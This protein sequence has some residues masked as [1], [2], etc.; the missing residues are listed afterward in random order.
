MTTRPLISLPIR[1]HFALERLWSLSRREWWLGL[2]DRLLVVTAALA[3]ILEWLPVTTLNIS[4]YLWGLACLFL[5]DHLIIYVTVLFSR[6]HLTELW[7]DNYPTVATLLGSQEIL[8]DLF[9]RLNIASES[10]IKL[11]SIPFDLSENNLK[12]PLADLLL[13][14]YEA[15]PEAKSLLERAGVTA[16]QVR[17]A[18]TWI[19][20]G[21]E[22]AYFKQAWWR[23]ENLATIPGLAKDWH[24]GETYNLEQYGHFIEVPEH[25]ATFRSPAEEAMEQVLNREKEANVV[26][27]GELSASLQVLAELGTRINHG[28]TWPRLE[29]KQLLLLETGRLLANFEHQA[30]LPETL[31]GLVT[32]A[33]L[34]GNVILVI[35]DLP[36]LSA[37][38]TRLGTPLSGLLDTYLASAALTVIGLSDP[39]S[40]HGVLEP[41]AVLMN[42]FETV[43]VEGAVGEQVLNLVG[44]RVLELEQQ[45]GLYFTY[46]AV[47]ALAQSVENYFSAGTPAAEAEDLMSELIPA[48]IKKGE[49]RVGKE[50]ILNFVKT[51]TKIPMG[52]VSGLEREKLLSLEKHLS[53]RVVGQERAL[54]ALSSAI[55][56]SR[57]GTRS[58]SRPIGTFL[59]LGPTGVGK[60]ETA[61]ALAQTLFGR[62]EDLLRL[63]MSEY[64]SNDSLARLIGDAGSGTPGILAKL[65]RE[66][67]YGVLLLDEFEKTER[68]VLNLF[69]QIFDE[70]FFSDMAGRRVNMRSLVMIATSNAGA[71]LIWK[72]VDENQNLESESSKITDYLIEQGLFKPELLNRFDSV[73]IF[74]PL[75][76]VALKD[77][78]KRELMKL[79]KRLEDQGVTLVITDLL[80]E[81]LA[82]RG[83]NRQFGARP[84]KRLLQETVEEEVAKALI[85]GTLIS[86]HKVS[87]IPSKNPDGNLLDLDL[88]V[89]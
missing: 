39:S 65:A 17:S 44:T 56:R 77:I 49:R 74:E 45:T 13:Q 72:L 71:Q 32:E 43:T 3:L 52:E 27:V 64:A 48:L 67:P 37:Y 7:S 41:D 68:E 30:G 20:A 38:L 51:K 36:R 8:L 46:Q 31:L 14:A 63:D 70:G 18:L 55:R 59:F 23:W 85:A 42:R 89:E 19:I 87:F 29:G 61:K 5:A 66:H 76:E 21:R 2:A 78:A 15:N 28:V 26:L 60:T 25:L 80:V 54:A 35:D 82:K 1:L 58:A 73:V 69:L 57:A 33:A 75:S 40:F 81:T 12:L 50:D 22:R 11:L 88:H 16:G 4:P 34:A 83:A 62:E 9:N 79:K 24:Y 47:Q 53:E 6:Y 84:L 10:Q 86:G